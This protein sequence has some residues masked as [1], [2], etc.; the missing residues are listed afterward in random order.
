MCKTHRS[1]KMAV[2]IIQKNDKRQIHRITGVGKNARSAYYDMA[3]RYAV[4][5]EPED[6]FMI[7]KHYNDIDI[8]FKEIP[9]WIYAYFEE[10][11]FEEEE[12]PEFIKTQIF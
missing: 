10:H 6:Y 4:P 12:I 9:E 2:I 8:E 5:Q 1:K 7:H 3:G 11:D